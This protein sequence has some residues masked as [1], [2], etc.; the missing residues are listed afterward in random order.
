M[1]KPLSI[2][3]ATLFVTLACGCVVT[4]Y[5][6]DRTGKMIEPCEKHKETK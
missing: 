4:V 3:Y 1:A 6:K 5:V 2:E